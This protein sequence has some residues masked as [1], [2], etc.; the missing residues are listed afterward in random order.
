MPATFPAIFADRLRAEGVTLRPEYDLFYDRRRV[1]SETELAGMRR[2]QRAAEGGM[3]AARDLLRRASQ[4]GAGLEVDGEPLT[5]ERD[6]GGDRRGLHEARDD[7]RRVH[8]LARRAVGR[9]ARHGVGADR[10]GRA[11]RDRPLAA[12]HRD[13]VLRGHDADV[14]RRR[15]GRG[16][17]PLPH[18]LQGG[19]RPVVG[20]DP[21]RASRGRTSS[22]SSASSSTRPAS[23]RSS[24]RPTGEVLQDGF[25]HGLGHGVGLEVHE[26][27]SLGRAPGSMVAGDVVTV[28]P[29]LYKH[30]Y[31]G[32]RL[33]DLV[34]VTE[35]GAENLTDYP[36]DLRSVSE[37]P[38][39]RDPPRR[40]AAISAL[41]R[42]RGAGERAAVDLR[43]VVRGAVGARGARAGD[44]VR[45]VLRAVR[46]G[47]PVREVVPRREAERVL[48]LRRP[49]R[50]GRARGEGRV[51]LGGRAGGRPPLGHLCRSVAGGDAA[52]E[53]AQVA[54]RRE[55]HAGRDLHGDDPGAAGRDARVRAARG[56][57]HRR[58]RRVL[59]GVALVADG[60]HGLRGADH[61]GR[62]VAARDD[63]AAE[64][65]R[66]RGDGRRA[67]RCARASSSGGRAARRR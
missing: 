63:R 59:G 7:L 37:R 52:R 24:R 33:E 57:A 19:A 67:A 53:R 43:G 23:R 45:A 62:G 9:R 66:R 41:A 49:A 51:L 30:G 18:A 27:P 10:R 58:L 13:A 21:R 15:A 28:E 26:A 42:V 65:D 31:G 22:G 56:A 6:Q 32:V 2:A 44:V 3:D 39:D 5:C 25:Y 16:H 54:R 4:N 61:P 50:R 38:D 12:R 40:G 60:G 11:G 36:Y 8:R 17:R 35:S 29:G 1:K 48:Q 46:V 47:A 20:R 14:R 55:G 64:G 34:L